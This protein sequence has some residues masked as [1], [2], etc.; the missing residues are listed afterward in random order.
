MHSIPDRRQTRRSARPALVVLGY[1]NVAARLD[2]GTGTTARS[3][4]TPV[5]LPSAATRYRVYQE[6]VGP[7]HTSQ[8]ATYNVNVSPSGQ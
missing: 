2:L 6:P 3:N 1:D 4:G 7:P 5:E 8:A